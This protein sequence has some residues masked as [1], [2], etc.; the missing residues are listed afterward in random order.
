MAQGHQGCC[1][2]LVRE[3]EVPPTGMNHHVGRSAFLNAL[4]HQALQHLDI[5]RHHRGGPPRYVGYPRIPIGSILPTP[6]ACSKLEMRLSWSVSSAE[7]Q[8]IQHFRRVRGS[9]A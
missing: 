7:S 6:A 5:E 3:Q 8:Q 4:E 9:P 2:R 1:R